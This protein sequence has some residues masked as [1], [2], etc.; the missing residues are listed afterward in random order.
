L[1]RAGGTFLVRTHE[2]I[3]AATQQEIDACRTEPHL[4][5]S[6]NH[7]IEIVLPN[8]PQVSPSGEG[9]GP[10]RSIKQLDLTGKR[11][12]V[13]ERPLKI[14]CKPT[15]EAVSVEAIILGQRGNVWAALERNA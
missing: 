13:D 4:R 12:S 6:C 11:E 8:L 1:L 3:Q 9:L 7:D 2:E 15:G 10:S 14:P 5:A